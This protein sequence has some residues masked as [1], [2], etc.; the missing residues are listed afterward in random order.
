VT[1]YDPDF[2]P[3]GIQAFTSLGEA[4]LAPVVWRDEPD[5]NHVAVEPPWF[6]NADWYN[7]KGRVT[8]WNV[9]D[10]VVTADFPGGLK[11]LKTSHPDV[12]RALIDVFQWWIRVSNIDGFRIDT[13][14]HV[15]HEFWQEFSPAMRRLAKSLGKEKFFQFG[16]AFD[17]NDALVGSF[18][19]NNELDSAFYFP[20]KFQ[21]LD[22]VFKYNQ[23]TRKIE[24]LL[25]ERRRNYG[26]S[27]H[28]D[29]IG[30]PPQQALVTFIDNHDVPRFLFNKPSLAALHSALF[31]L[32]TWDGIPC[33]Y[34]GTEQAFAGGNDPANRERLWDSGYDTGNDT[35]QHIQRLIAVR[36]LYPPLRR[37][38]VQMRW[39][40]DRTGAEQD[41]GAYAFERTYENETVLVVGNASDSNTA[42]TALEGSLMQTAFP[43]G[44]RLRNVLADD[45]PLDD[46]TVGAG[47]RLTVRVPPRGGKIL[48][49]AD[50][51]R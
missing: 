13:L 33:I 22:D 10:Q 42:E 32:L 40:S 5:S 27:P 29:G 28:P 25:A 38:D 14:K 34:Y 51:V 24:N 46:F 26:A 11:D 6:R 8:D 36:K 23:P 43:E 39:V 4:G 35:F 50:R 9:F 20:L 47:G 3:D 12:R 44:T 21:V 17:G 31:F 45:D 30:V 19:R 1:E 48:V 2:R 37:G 7:R 15:E 41:A 49:R 16:E 18:T